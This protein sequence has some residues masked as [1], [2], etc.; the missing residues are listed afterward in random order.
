MKPQK[1]NLKRAQVSME[2][3][4]NIINVKEYGKL[5]LNNSEEVLDYFIFSTK[6]IHTLITLTLYNSPDKMSLSKLNS[7][8]ENLDTVIKKHLLCCHYSFCFSH[9]FV[10]QDNGFIFNKYFFNN[11]DVSDREKISKI[12]KLKKQINQIL[13]NFI[14]ETTITDFTDTLDGKD[15]AMK[16]L[17]AKFQPNIIIVP[18][19]DSYVKLSKNFYYHLFYFFGLELKKISDLIEL[20]FS[21]FLDKGNTSIKS[22]TSSQKQ[23]LY[24]HIF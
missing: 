23:N 18:E 14:E 3:M 4:K 13:E 20:N 1:H 9:F 10:I 22:K 7:K 11:F 8:F 15:S 17:E 24:T 21:G 2:K 16:K 19:Q 12:S 5:D 6:D